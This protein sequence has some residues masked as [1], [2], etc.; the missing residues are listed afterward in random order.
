[1]TLRYSGGLS[2]N[3]V[4]DMYD[5]ARG[6]GGF[7]RSLALTAHLVIN[8]EIIT[9]APALKGAQIIASTPEEGSWK[10]TAI[11]VAGVWAVVNAPKESPVG[12]LIYSAYDYAVNSSLGFHVDYDK[13]L[14]AQY[15]EHLKAK[16]ITPEK[17]DSLIE[18]VEPSVSEMHR[19]IIASGTAT[20]ADITAHFEMGS[21]RKVGPLM[22]SL[23]YEYLSRSVRV[24][25]VTL[26]EGAISSFNIN[27][28]KGRI[29]SFEDQRPIPFE[30][31]Q[32]ARD[33][34][35][36]VAITSSLRANAASRFNRTA[37]VRLTVTRFESPSGRLKSL[38]VR[39]VTEL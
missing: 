36:L 23:T 25:Q 37:G 11:V 9:Q 15:E 32:E 28:M 5:A 2:D 22:S 24:D 12:H 8:G 7:Q 29:F 20:Q 16:K 39:Q 18:K 14:G 26:L 19:P 10:V 1:M 13:S 33:T 31:G 30:L 21:P 17:M 3:N 27:T 4:L 35:S 38:I 6:L 34:A